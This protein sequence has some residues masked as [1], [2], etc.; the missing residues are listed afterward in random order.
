MDKERACEIL[1]ISLDHKENAKKAYLRL[2]KEKH[3]DRG[4]DPEEFLRIH[5]AY[6]TIVEM[7]KPDAFRTDKVEFN[8]KVGLEEAVF[9]VTVQTHIRPQTASTTSLPEK[10]KS[11]V[12]MDMLTVTESIPPMSLLNGPIVKTYPGKMVGGSER[13]LVVCYSLREHERYRLCKDKKKALLSVEQSIPVMAAL[14]GGVV[15][16]ETMFGPRKLNIRA[17]TNIGDSYVIKNHGPLGGL[18]VVISGVEMPVV[19]DPSTLEVDELRQRE[20]DEE[21]R[22]LHENDAKA[23]DIKRDLGGRSAASSQ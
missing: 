22:I 14:Q 6:K 10:G 9:G 18:E 1:G 21:D 17:G 5:E 23:D 12:Y 7:E 20:V 3:P 8:V 4:G 16:V 11:A 19:D 2:S 13:E 15:E